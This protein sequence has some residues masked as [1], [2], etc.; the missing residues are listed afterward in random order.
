MKLSGLGKGL[1]SLIPK[2]SP[3]PQNTISP[4]SDNNNLKTKESVFLIEI[5]RVKE[6]PYQP[7]RDFNKE[8]LES[9]AG[10][11]REHGILQPLIVTKSEEETASGI[12]VSYE[13]VAGERRLKAAK[14]AG[15]EFIPAV[16][17]PKTEEKQKLELALIEN[18]QRAD[19]NAVEKARGYEKLQKEFNLTQKEIAKRIG[20]S[21]EAVANAV[22]LLGLPIEIQKAIESGKISEGHGRAILAIETDHQK[23]VM[24]NEILGKNLSVRA[25][26][27]LG[28]QAK[29]VAKKVKE[30]ALDAESKELES[31]L[32]EFFGT[33]VK[34]AKT[35]NRGRILIEFYSPEELNSILKKILNTKYY[36]L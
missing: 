32:E 29:G 14:I 8:E 3:A 36:I 11:I 19:L 30:N 1:E 9:L 17:R 35:G 5:D 4:R 25:T 27:S 7:R 10:S 23:L 28:R 34:L 24:L 2:N 21:R 13:L 20:Q 26:E 22:R 15:L 6:N 18:I 16:I 12:K 31:R 33:R